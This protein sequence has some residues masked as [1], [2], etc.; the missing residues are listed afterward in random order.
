[1]NR[2]RAKLQARR[3]LSGINGSSR[4]V[5]NIRNLSS[6]GDSKSEQPRNIIVSVIEARI[7]LSD[8]WPELRSG[9][10]EP[11][12]LGPVAGTLTAT[13]EFRFSQMRHQS[14]GQTGDLR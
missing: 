6:I 14:C 5:I 12:Q 4:T 3:D 8:R 7:R 1:M 9:R 10:M 13:T 11:R 2:G